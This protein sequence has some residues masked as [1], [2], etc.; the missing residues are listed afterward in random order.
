MSI[1]K[2]LTNDSLRVRLLEA[3]TGE[4]RKSIFA[5]TIKLPLFKQAKLSLAS[6][7]LNYSSHR[8]LNYHGIPRY[9]FS[10]ALDENE[11]LKDFQERIDL[12]KEEAHGKFEE[13]TVKLQ[14]EV[15]MAFQPLTSSKNSGDETPLEELDRTHKATIER[16]GE[17][18]ARLSLSSKERE[19]YNNSLAGELEN[20][21]IKSLLELEAGRRLWWM[22]VRNALIRKSK[23]GEDNIS[24]T[25]TNYHV[26]PACYWYWNFGELEPKR[27]VLTDPRD[28]A[29]AHVWSGRTSVQPWLL[30]K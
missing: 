22:M 29:H 6:K 7:H 21:H 26:P 23:E 9:Y 11:S 27:Q 13:A 5:E 2:I 14:K 19:S 10:I 25:S 16:F 28:I 4:L 8:L 30:A 15:A 17:A 3:E 20:A 24:T 1:E 12:A 18:Y